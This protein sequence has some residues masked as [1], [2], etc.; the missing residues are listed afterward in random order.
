MCA[1]PPQNTD[2][3]T[4]RLKLFGN[5]TRRAIRI[6][7]RSTRSQANGMGKNRT[8][9]SNQFADIRVALLSSLNTSLDAAPRVT[10]LSLAALSM[11][12]HDPAHGLKRDGSSTTGDF[13]RNHEHLPS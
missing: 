8:G 12:I 10:L 1:G 11:V 2:K 3:C 6:G 7:L 13:A 4:V 9:G 5:A